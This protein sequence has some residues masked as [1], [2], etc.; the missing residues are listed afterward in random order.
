[1]VKENAVFWV[2]YMQRQNGIKNA[3]LM[4]KNQQSLH[5][6]MQLISKTLEREN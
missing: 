2:F 3:A 6:E 5:V 4:M 1:M